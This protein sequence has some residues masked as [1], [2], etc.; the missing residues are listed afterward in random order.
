M[1]TI[2]ISAV[3]LRKGGTLTILRNCLEYLS[4]LAQ[5][6][7]YRIVALVHRKE[8]ALY[9]GIEYIEMPESLRDRYQ[10]Y[11]RAEMGK[12]HALGFSDEAS[13]LK[14]AIADYM[15]Y[16]QTERDL[17]ELQDRVL[18]LVLQIHLPHQHPPQRL[19]AGAAGMD[20]AGVR[21]H[22]PPPAG[23]DHRDPARRK[24]GRPPFRI[25]QGFRIP[26]PVCLL[27]R[28]PQEFRN[29]LPGCPIAGTGDR[30]GKIQSRPDHRRY[31]KPVHT[32]A[33]Q[34]L[35]KGQLHRVCRIHGPQ[36]AV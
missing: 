2:V 4:T 31:R 28:H 3:N 15:S 21:R 35:G 27:W 11:T 9:P 32:L 13:S 10:Y 23:T 20:Q 19:G 1:K 5:T 16:M 6:G 24:R 7:E 22:V 29:A 17:P 36:Q 8:L 25:R 12:Y 30:N 18:R 33:L 26:F 34:T 14:D